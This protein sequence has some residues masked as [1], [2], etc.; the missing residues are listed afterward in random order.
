M[1][2]T[3]GAFVRLKQDPARA[4][5]L[6]EGKK[7]A[8][9]APMVQM[10]FSDGQVKWVPYSALELVPSP[11][12]SLSDRFFAGR[13]VEPEWLRR[14]L[15]RLRVAGRLSNVVYSMEATE[16]DFYAYQ[17]KPVVKLMGSPTDSL[18]IA[19]E[20]GLGKTIE[21]GLVWTELRAR[22][23]C[24]RLLVVCPKTLCQKWQDELASRF[25]VD[26]QIGD[27]RTL[28]RALDQAKESGRGYALICSMQ[29]LRPPK[30]WDDDGGG[31]DGANDSPRRQLARFLDDAGDGEPLIDLL[32]VDEAHHMRNPETL[33]NRFGRLINSVASHR[34]FL[35]ATPI[36]LRN[37]DLHS[38]LRMVDADTFEFE[39]TLN[40][41]IETNAPIIAARDL[42][43]DADCSVDLILKQLDEAQSHEVLRQSRTL[44]QIRQVLARSEI[45]QSKRSELASRIERVNQL[46]N[47]V[48]RTRRRDVQEF[49]VIREP[50]APTLSMSEQE[51][52]FY[53]EITEVVKDYAWDRDA[54]EL[55]LLS[56][57]QRL[58]TSS[59]AAASAYWCGLAS[60]G[61]PAGAD[62]IEESDLDLQGHSLG[63]HP[64]LA[65]IA[66]RAHS[67][68]ITERLAKADAKY[69][70][71]VGELQQLWRVEAT[72]KVIVFS[73][74]KPTLHYLQDRLRQD[75][76]G[77][78]LLH[79]SVTRPR[80]EIL[81][82]FQRADDI[83]V[84]LSSEVGSEGV[85]LQ[86]SSIV[87]NYDMP[88]NPMRL[89]QR[90]GRVDRLGQTKEKVTILNLIYDETIDKRIY[91]RLYERL[92]IGKRAL[93]G[94]EA[95][96]GQPIREMRIKLLDPSLS[97]EQKE[98]I[99][100]QTAQALENR[101]QEEEQLEAEAGS[102]VQHGD[103]IL[104][105]IMES[106]EQH[107]WLSAND[108]LTY[109][110]DRILRDFPGSVIETSPAGSDTYRIELSPAGA[111][112]FRTYLA[113]R[114]LKARTRLLNSSPRQRFR[115]S[116]SV[117][118]KDG[119][120]ETI[121][122]LHP[123]VRF[124]A[125]RDLEDDAARQAQAVAATLSLN[126]LP[127][128]LKCAPGL[129]AL[130]ARRWS[131]GSME[132]FALTNVR[133]GYAGA[134]AGT[135]ALMHSDLVEQLVGIT[136][137]QGRPM[138]NA[139]MHKEL[140]VVAATLQEV[141]YPE[142][143]RRFS[144]FIDEATAEIKDRATI[145]SQALTRHFEDRIALL[146]EQGRRMNEQAF[147]A[148][149]GGDERRAVNLRNL[150]KA[151][152]AMGEKLRRTWEL[153]EMEL[154]AQS[155]TIPEESDVVGVFLQVEN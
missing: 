28:V 37:R 130:A 38:L 12:E 14:T 92:Q 89:E 20:V 9:G 46:A 134:C 148:G 145:R 62:D 22:L 127:E 66:Q 101:K 112:A 86:F 105:R 118:R 64:L 10:H 23:D 123:L 70:L 75:G 138:L 15:T 78:E 57:P 126:V 108:V 155:S 149:R 121:S 80:M 17:F 107:R 8:A 81:R 119:M 139:G 25:G 13:F 30:G 84:L 35:S 154:E 16:T 124:A 59:L 44:A 32:V 151:R 144:Q 52:F 39:S 67:L 94:M 125:E 87:I 43:L 58:L 74:F 128:N 33:I 2:I 18:L 96:L 11:A 82:R 79:G 140:D 55:F 117:V 91:E 136:A 26:A 3:V 90:I 99:I 106:R 31:G 54:N 142:L 116:S 68:D 147:Q 1:S 49:R 76:I 114:G 40:D 98:K 63:E 100:D 24:D 45:D 4:G 133:I 113:R 150:A 131:T 34:L 97:N 109:I 153:R 61:S 51:R 42:L 69:R 36:H 111:A 21:A 85:D 83:R 115:F 129:Y 6:L 48:T 5:S 7:V 53:E 132:T 60:A 50:K 93:G 146:K 65:R 19:D 71:L 122:Q 143:D 95:I 56:S 152:V 104:E 29:G 27:A 135:G 110:R 47:Y 72:A 102:L 120:V 73:S 137:H 103:Y 88:W 41:L 141:V 77:V